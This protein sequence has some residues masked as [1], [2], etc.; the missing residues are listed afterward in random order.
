MQWLIQNSKLAASVKMV[1]IGRVK[2][3]HETWSEDGK[4]QKVDPEFG[5]GLD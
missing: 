5:R 2:Y 1:E 4:W 3:S